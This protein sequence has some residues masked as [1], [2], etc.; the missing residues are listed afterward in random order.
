MTGQEQQQQ[1]NFDQRADTAATAIK[2]ELSQR[3]GIDLPEQKVQVGPDGQPARPLPPEGSYMRQLVEQQRAEQAAMAQ[4]AMAQQMTAP[5]PQQQPPQQQVGPPQQQVP[6]QPQPPQGGDQ[7]SAKAEERIQELV[8]M[9]RSKDQELQQ[10]QQQT[11]QQLQDWQKRFEQRNAEYEELVKQQLE[12]LSPEDRMQVL[13]SAAIREAVA[14]SEQRILGAIAPKL[15]VFEEQ[16]SQRELQ[17]LAD[18]YPGFDPVA[19]VPL[20][21]EFRKHNPRCSIEHALRATVRPEV[22]MAVNQSRPAPAVPPTPAPG[23]G[24]VMPRYM[25]EPQA[26]PEKEMVEEA[27]KA[28]DL[29]RSGKPEDQIEA[30]RLF[31]KNLSDRLAHRLPQRPTFQ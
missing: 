8:N 29:A 17:R 6:P 28:R 16:E 24:A 9:L 31:H 23:N 19:H 27:A 7:V 14:E 22:L 3:L 15:R 10:T 12:S 25:P 4:Q 21:D 18:A 13:Q 26:D 20:I 5:Q 1:S 2:G 11:Q 30:Q